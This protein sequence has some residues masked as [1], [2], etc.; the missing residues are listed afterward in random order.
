M[1]NIFLFTLISFLFIGIT[2]CK[3]D[4]NDSEVEVD[5]ID[6][7]YTP[8]KE[9]I[10]FETIMADIDANMDY[11]TGNSLF[12]TNPDGETADVQI[13][14]DDKGETKKLVYYH[15]TKETSSLQLSIFYFDQGN[16]VVT[17]ELFDNGTAFQERISYYDRDGKVLYTKSRQAEFEEYLSVE[18][19]KADELTACDITE[20]LQVLNQEGRYAVTFRGFVEEEQFLYLIVGEDKMDGFTSSLVVQNMDNSI[21]ELKK[22]ELEHIGKP[23]RIE[24]DRSAGAEGFEYQLLV[25]ASM[26]DKQEK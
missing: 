12:Y 7:E 20:A 22:T 5:N 9:E 3:S 15:T 11:Q 24:F 23:M 16:N 21:M 17:R 8:T 19:F 10:E 13:F 2:S 4:K 1:K 14:V 18:Q 25:S 26:S 6:S